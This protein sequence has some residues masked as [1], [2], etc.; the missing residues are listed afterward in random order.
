MEAYE[1]IRTRRTIRKFTDVPV[2][3]D[4]IGTILYAGNA[5]PSAGNLQ[6]WKFVIVTEPETI[7]G[8]AEACL[9]QFWIETAPVVIVVCAVPDRTKQ[10]Y[11]IR[12]E[13]LYSIQ[14]GAAAAQNMLLAAHSLG[15]GAAWVGA[16]DEG[17]LART[18]NIPDF[19][20]PQVII[21]IGYPDE[22]APEPAKL[23]LENVSFINAY[24]NRIRD[25]NALF[26]YTSATIRKV[27][28][29]G[30]EAFKKLHKHVTKKKK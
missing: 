27:L 16:F 23:T 22:I 26:G 10:F 19:A 4:K 17:M 24:G 20:R 11:G 29:K 8:I 9:K 21:P 3:W 7:K 25:I 5:A 28:G 15:L 12:G 1:C 13:R 6:D 14:S 18:L 30:A 2:E